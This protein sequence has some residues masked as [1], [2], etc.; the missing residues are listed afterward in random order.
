MRLP[1]LGKSNGFTLVEVM[2]ASAL[3]GIGIAATYSTLGQGFNIIALAREQRRATQILLQTTETLRLYTWD[4]IHATSFM[5]NQFLADYA[6]DNS[7]NSGTAY[8]IGLTVS[9]FPTSTEQY[10]DNICQVQVTVDWQTHG[11]ARHREL[12]TFVTRYG[13][14]NCIY[15]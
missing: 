5:P 12:T 6:P 2:M 3:L 11:I 9:P 7:T 15:Y 1:Q 10:H 13:L 4:Q 14:Q 8:T